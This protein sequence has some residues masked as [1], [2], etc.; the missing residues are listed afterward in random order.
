MISPNRRAEPILV[1]HGSHTGPWI[2]TDV[3]SHLSEN[4][5]EVEAVSLPGRGDG[6]IPATDATLRAYLDAV[7]A[8][9]GLFAMPARAVADSPW[10][11]ASRD[12][13]SS[14]IDR[15]RND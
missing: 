1:V 4:N 7:V 2:W 5:A 6:S 9:M 8:A 12:I 15:P 13:R 14:H 10:H 3:S 11:V